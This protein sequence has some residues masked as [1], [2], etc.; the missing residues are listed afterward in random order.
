MF[1]CNHRGTEKQRKVIVVSFRMLVL[2]SL[3]FFQ[4]ALLLCVSVPRWL[5]KNEIIQSSVHNRPPTKYLH[6]SEV[7]T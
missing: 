4:S 5:Q 1:F 7:S 6:A 2:Q 3:S